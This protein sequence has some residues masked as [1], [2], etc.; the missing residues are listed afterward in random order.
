VFANT[1]NFKIRKTSKKIAETNCGLLAKAW[2]IFL[3][4][5][6]FL[7]FQQYM[8]AFY[9][10][11]SSKIGFLLSVK[12]EQVSYISGLFFCSFALMQIPAGL[13]FDKFN[14]KIIY[15]ICLTVSIFALVLLFLLPHYYVSLLASV[16]L[17]ASMSIAFIGGVILIIRWFK[18]EKFSLIIGLYGGLGFIGTGLLSSFAMYL[19]ESI[20]INKIA[21]LMILFDVLILICVFIFIKP[22]QNDQSK[23]IS[24]IETKPDILF[25]LKGALLSKHVW[26]IGIYNALMFGSAFAFS[27]FWNFSYQKTFNNSP[28]LIIIINNMILFGMALGAPFVG[29]LSQKIKKRVLPARIFSIISLIC[30]LLILSGIIPRTYIYFIMFI[31]GMSS[32]ISSISFSYAKEHT[33]YHFH[34]TASGIINTISFISVTFLQIIPG[35]ILSNLDLNFT[36][37]YNHSIAFLF[38][39]IFI[40]LAF[41]CTFFMK[42]TFCREQI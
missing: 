3:T 41:L 38:F 35:I 26:I 1:F 27:T 30:I 39:P 31:F 37:I 36:A 32:N 5:A 8:G 19:S 20:S 2:L 23:S 18:S 42:E 29:W 34:G 28:D 21:L 15:R 22:R 4:A 40:L 9:G 24:V 13:M 17:G 25:I 7:V 11:F 33:Q 10:I 6:L 14:V 12:S 16:L